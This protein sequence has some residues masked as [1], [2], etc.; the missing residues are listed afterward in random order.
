MM[1]EDVALASGRRGVVPA[2]GVGY[3]NG[4]SV[5]KDTVKVSV[6]IFRA[7]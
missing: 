5:V 7:R 6:Q 3:L 4:V 1:D 2:V